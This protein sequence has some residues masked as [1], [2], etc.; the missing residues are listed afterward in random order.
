MFYVFFRRTESLCLIS[1]P[2]VKQGRSFA[3][4]AIR[5]VII[6][7]GSTSLL[8]NGDKSPF[9]KRDR[10]AKRRASNFTYTSYKPYGSLVKQG[11]FSLVSVRRIFRRV[12]GGRKMALRFPSARAE[13]GLT[14]PVG[15]CPKICGN[16]RALTALPQKTQADGYR[17][18]VFSSF[19]LRSPFGEFCARE[20]Q[21]TCLRRKK[22]GEIM[23][24]RFQKPYESYMREDG[25]RMIFLYNFRPNDISLGLVFLLPNGE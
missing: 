22:H 20:A 23:A 8:P 17:K 19:N 3:G 14:V 11:V 5:Y 7:I 21:E 16:Y 13:N 18:A 4:G 1:G 24:L 9:G 12:K 15:L 25:L 2:L 6:K 10:Q